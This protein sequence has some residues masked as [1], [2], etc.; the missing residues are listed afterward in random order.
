MIWGQFGRRG[1]GATIG[2]ASV[3]LLRIGD[4][5][6]VFVDF[7]GSIVVTV[8]LSNDT[9]Y[10]GGSGIGASGGGIGSAIGGSP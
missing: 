4:E 8:L 2:P 6:D 3:R 7:E 10:V 9:K 1:Q 5:D